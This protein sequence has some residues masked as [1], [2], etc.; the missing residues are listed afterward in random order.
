MKSNNE[1]LSFAS[2]TSAE[3]TIER[4]LCISG[5]SMQTIPA[6]FAR[7]LCLLI[8]SCASCL[9]TRTSYGGEEKGLCSL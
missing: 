1:L 6:D 8:T 4:V 2:F 3:Y 5:Q 9:C 7:N